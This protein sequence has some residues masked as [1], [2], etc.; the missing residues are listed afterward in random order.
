MEKTNCNSKEVDEMKISS[1][2]HISN[3]VEKTWKGALALGQ[4]RE[5]KSSSPSPC[6]F[7]CEIVRYSFKE[8]L[9]WLRT[10][11]VG[12]SSFKFQSS[13]ARN[14]E[15]FVKSKWSS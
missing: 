12:K 6:P 1:P 3:Q 13:A 9:S 5:F 11:N 7:R 8:S 4:V 2:V 15:L 14:K 10:L